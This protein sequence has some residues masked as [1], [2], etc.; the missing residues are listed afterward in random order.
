MNEIKMRVRCNWCEWE[1]NEDELKIIDY[2]LEV[3][4]VCGRHDCLMDLNWDE[5][6]KGGNGK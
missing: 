1:G 5:V 2:E 4:P 6:Y 3:C